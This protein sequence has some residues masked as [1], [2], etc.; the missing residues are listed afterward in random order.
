MEKRRVSDARDV[1]EIADLENGLGFVRSLRP[2]QWRENQRSW[3]V[4]RYKLSLQE[5]DKL[6]KY[7][8][9]MGSYDVWAHERAEKAASE[10]LA[11]FV[12]QEAG[13][14][15]EAAYGGQFSGLVQ[16]SRQV[17]AL[18]IPE[19]VE[20]TLS[21][22]YGDLVPFLTAAIQDLDALYGEQL[23]T[24]AEQLSCL[25]AEVESLKEWIRYVAQR[26]EGQ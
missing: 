8:P 6:D 23:K 4:D 13:A 22:S 3:Y 16:N 15:S 21:L 24:Q 26:G 20:S 14:A 19:D 11:G 5:L 12:A 10:W 1:T 9:L 25:R 7:G 2:R 17:L 18:E